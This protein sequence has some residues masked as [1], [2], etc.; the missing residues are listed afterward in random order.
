ML[1]AVLRMFQFMSAA[2]G[3]HLRR[4]SSLCKR[5]RGSGHERDA[6]DDGGEGVANF[7]ED[8]D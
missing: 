4:L 6:S 8:D 5:G 1:G 2:C 7:L 3:W